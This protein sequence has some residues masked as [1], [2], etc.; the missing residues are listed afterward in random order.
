MNSKQEI[1]KAESVLADLEQLITSQNVPY[2]VHI[3]R[4][5]GLKYL[6][7]RLKELQRIETES[8]KYRNPLPEGQEDDIK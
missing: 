4:L 1:E 7:T 6:H 5:A 8:S 2:L 3:E